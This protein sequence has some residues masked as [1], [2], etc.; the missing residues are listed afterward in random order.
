M[1]PTSSAAE[2]IGVSLRTIEFPRVSASVGMARGRR[3]RRP[4]SHG[5]GRRAGQDDAAGQPRA[6]CI[7]DGAL[8]RIA[9]AGIPV[10]NPPRAVEAAVDKYLTLSLLERA[11]IPVPQTWTGESASE[12]LEAFAALGATWSSS[13]SSDPRDAG[14]CG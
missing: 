5:V 12:A 10:L 6:S 9:A 2:Q 7:P 4:R 14:W 3:G 8:H 11:G 1:S 13:R